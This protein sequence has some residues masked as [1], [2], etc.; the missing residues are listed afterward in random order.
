M[1]AACVVPEVAGVLEV[2]VV[3]AAAVTADGDQQGTAVMCQKAEGAGDAGQAIFKHLIS[4]A[5]RQVMA[6]RL[7]AFVDCGVGETGEPRQH[8][9]DGAGVPG[10]CGNVQVAGTQVTFEKIVECAQRLYDIVDELSNLLAAAVTVISQFA[11][12]NCGGRH[13]VA[14]AL[15]EHAEAAADVNV[16][17][18]PLICATHSELIDGAEQSVSDG[19]KDHGALGS[20]GGVRL[21]RR[22]VEDAVVE[23]SVVC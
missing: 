23:G 6:M 8:V 4:F 9:P 22:V 19:Q 17:I 3:E 21:F 12:L 16:V 5:T 14:A 1:K 20:L 7:Y 11:V 18:R 13:T 2:G 15:E 10:L